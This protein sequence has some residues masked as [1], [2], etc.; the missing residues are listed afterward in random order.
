MSI[1]QND[2]PRKEKEVLRSMIH[3]KINGLYYYYLDGGLLSTIVDDSGI[4]LSNGPVDNT[5]IL[6]TTNAIANIAYAPFLNLTAQDLYRVRFDTERYGTVFDYSSSDLETNQSNN[7]PFVFRINTSNK[8]KAQVVA[9]VDLY[10]KNRYV[11]DKDRRFD[12][13]SESKLLN[14]PYRTIMFTSNIFDQYEVIPQMMDIVPRSET[15]KIYLKATTPVNPGGNFYV[16]VP[17]YKGDVAGLTERMYA[18]TSMDIPNTSS[19]YSNYMSTQK[20]RTAV[21]TGTALVAGAA[22]MIGGIATGNPIAFAGGMASVGS[23]V[24]NNMAMKQDLQSTPNSLKTMGGDMLTRLGTEGKPYI[25][26]CEKQITVEN[27]LQ[28]AHYF[29]LYGYKQNR[30]LSVGKILRRR[31]YY[32]YIKTIGCNIEGT[33]VPKKHLEKIKNIF[34]N[35]TTLWHVD[36]QGVKMYDYSRENA[37]VNPPIQY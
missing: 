23:A 21:S 13:R 7:L 19:A 12:Y 11:P 4:P 1:N 6:G 33:G 14:Y 27:Q 28:I 22:G 10:P 34:N 32:N 26:A 2:I 36:R 20:A 5:A 3:G 18:G 35:G 37:E 24:A 15:N 9:E 8:P 25:I 31:Y 29:H 17:G 30:M 16:N